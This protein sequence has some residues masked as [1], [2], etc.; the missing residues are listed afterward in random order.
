MTDS[1]AQPAYEL[2]PLST[3]EL[4]DRTFTI[5]RRHFALF[6]GIMAIP[7]VFTV[8]ATVGLLW[9][10]PAPPGAGGAEQDPMAFLAAAGTYFVSFVVLGLVAGIAYTIAG[11]ATTLALSRIYLGHQTTIRETYHSLRG[12]VLRLIWLFVMVMA[13]Y[14]GCFGGVAVVAIVA[15]AAAALVH[16]LLSAMIIGLLV[17]LG[18]LGTLVLLVGRF[19]VATPALVLEDLSARKAIARSASLTKGHRT[20]VILIYLLM[21]VIAYVAALLFQGPFFTLGLILRENG[22]PPLWTQLLGA[23]SGGIGGVMTGPLSRI[24]LTLLYYDV[25]VR[26]E[27][28]DLQLLMGNLRPDR[29]PGDIAAS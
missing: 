7:S 12:R 2:R 27:A 17:I 4:M 8:A 28:F 24:A 18:F 5:Y 15:G 16:P 22:Q 21:T 25:R 13:L 29:P 3:G 26:K 9:F 11:G 19:A 6:I 23:I 1:R 20:R 10:Q 14:V